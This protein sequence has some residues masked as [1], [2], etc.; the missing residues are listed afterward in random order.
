MTFDFA[1]LN[2]KLK[3][4]SLSFNEMKTIKDMENDNL[5]IIQI[6]SAQL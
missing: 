4:T 6:A 3:Q 5:L 1:Y 2:L